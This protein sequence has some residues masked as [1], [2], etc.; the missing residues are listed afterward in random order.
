MFF[1]F[2]I[3]PAV[4]AAKFEAVIGV[5]SKYLIKSEIPTRGQT[6]LL[7]AL[8]S[9]SQKLMMS[10]AHDAES[11]LLVMPKLE[12]LKYFNYFE[13]IVNLLLIILIM[14]ILLKI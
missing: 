8:H 5:T 11:S 7:D 12:S 6:G 1:K 10:H 2:A 13:D 9:M 3:I 14:L 4:S